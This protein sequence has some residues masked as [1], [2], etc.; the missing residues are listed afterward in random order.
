MSEPHAPTPKDS[1]AHLTTLL[2]GEQPNE[3]REGLLVDFS[4]VASLALIR[5]VT[6][7][8]PQGSS[9]AEELIQQWRARVEERMARAFQTARS[10]DGTVLG[11]MMI[12]QAERGFMDEL[13]SVE[14]ILRI[15]LLS[16]SPAPSATDPV[17]RP[18]DESGQG[19][20]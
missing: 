8:L 2:A 15:A 13:R 12:D 1:L 19:G 11:G 9:F 14:E 7:V 17:S 10:M 18:D 5:A 3:I 6:S 20:S 4:L 16:Q